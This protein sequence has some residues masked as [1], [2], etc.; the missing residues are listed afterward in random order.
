[1]LRYV[2]C[3]CFT[4]ICS[5]TSRHLTASQT[6]H[7]QLRRPD[8][9]F[10]KGY[11][12][13]PME[14]NFPIALMIQGAPCNSISKFH[15]D[16]KE[17]ITAMGMG[18]LSLEKRGVT[19]QAIDQEEYNRFNCMENRIADHLLGIQNLR[20]G[21][22]PGWTGQLI[23][24]GG[25]E[26]GMIGGTLAARI[27]ETT[28]LLL[29]ST[30]GGWKRRIEMRWA[31]Q[32]HLEKEGVSQKDIKRY[33]AWIEH[34]F[35]EMLFD[36]SPKKQFLG[37]TYKWWAS[38]LKFNRLPEDL[39]SLQCPIYYV[40]G[41]EDELIPIESADYLAEQF[42][43]RGKTNLLYRRL[44]GDMHS[45]SK[46]SESVFT[47]ALQWISQIVPDVSQP[48]FVKIRY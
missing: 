25:S 43:L 14:E 1:M 33:L 11:F 41:T 26:G 29:F 3:L 48:T 9:S 37:Y 8:G 39:L 17:K 20:E 12:T 35:D 40:H 6:Q 22:I 7:I 30:G 21:F 18:L 27:P 47:E 4:L 32:R 28:A 36:P 24:M 42:K 45:L 2:V 34:K 44:D 15:E 10:L 38:H 5:F 31:L 46:A 23:I 16:F 19:A 13:P